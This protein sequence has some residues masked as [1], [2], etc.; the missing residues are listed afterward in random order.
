[1]LYSGW[2]QHALLIRNPDTMVVEVGNTLN[3]DVVEIELWEESSSG[4]YIGAK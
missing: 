3:L 1:M 4:V 2:F